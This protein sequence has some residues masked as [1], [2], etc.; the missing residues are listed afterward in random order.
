[1]ETT[2]EHA[3]TTYGRSSAA[4]RFATTV[5][6]LGALGVAGSACGPR[7]IQAPGAGE[8]AKGDVAIVM[9]DRSVMAVRY[10]MVESVDGASVPSG[11]LHTQEIEVARGPHR[12]EVSYQE[13]DTRSTSNAF[14]AFTAEAGHR[15]RIHATAVKKGF[16]SEFRKNAIGGRG[17]W[18]TWVE[19][20][21][22][23]TVVGGRKPT[24]GMYETSFE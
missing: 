20:E 1:M 9:S 19:D 16:W 5:A 18:V 14:V 23:G 7:R 17:E 3:I 12:L 15:Y 24:M 21:P 11:K 2:H 6:L 22:S 13:G 10:V 4:R 8:H